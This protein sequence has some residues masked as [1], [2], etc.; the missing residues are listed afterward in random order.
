MSN[1]ETVVD[2][3]DLDGKG[4][5]LC[6]EKEETFEIISKTTTLN[7]SILSR[8]YTSIESYQPEEEKFFKQITPN[9]L[10][11]NIKGNM[12]LHCCDNH[13]SNRTISLI[14]LENENLLRII[15]KKIKEGALTFCFGYMEKLYKIKFDDFEHSGEKLK[16]NFGHVSPP[17]C[18]P[19][20]IKAKY[21]TQKEKKDLRPLFGLKTEDIY[22]PKFDKMMG[23]V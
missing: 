17:K 1:L 21:D 14:L 22:E 5:L 18:T 3:L 8:S 4:G 6:R 7:F 10:C 2:C 19:R 23:V 15:I 12:N 16:F 11:V 9:N 13:Q 20:T